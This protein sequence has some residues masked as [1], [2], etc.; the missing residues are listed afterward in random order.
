MPKQ[1]GIHKMTG[2][3]DEL[4]HY[5]TKYGFIVRRKGVITKERR[6]KAPEFEKLRN[7][8][9]DM[10]YASR[11]GKLLR[12]GVRQITGNKEPGDTN[13]RLVTAIRKV[14]KLDTAAQ[15]GDKRILPEYANMLNR[16]EWNEAAQVSSTLSATKEVKIDKDAGLVSVRMPGL[17]VAGALK[18]YAG[19][20][21]VEIS[22]GVTAIDYERDKQV[23]SFDSSGV[24]SIAEERPVDVLL[25]CEI[26]KDPGSVMVVGMAIQILQ[27]QAGDRWK[28]YG[29]SGYVVLE[30][31]V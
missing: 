19:A 14:L 16:F 31:L 7:S 25:E 11:M 26:P 20:T 29:G 28:M 10:A 27:D 22:L 30:V 1:G 24:L 8:S 6:A 18:Q 12:E 3:M 5:R 2:L 17:S 21:H 15:H 13:T 9:L 23:T 4:V